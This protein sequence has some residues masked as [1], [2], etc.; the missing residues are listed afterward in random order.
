[1]RNYWMLMIAGFFLHGAILLFFSSLL[2]ALKEKENKT[3]LKIKKNT[4]K[5]KKF[6]ENAAL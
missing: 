1:M 2:E 5:L 4:N 3:E 6:E